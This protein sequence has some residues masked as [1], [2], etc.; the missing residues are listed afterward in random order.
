MN[1]NESPQKLQTLWE[2]QD[3]LKLV[4]TTARD[5]VL[6]VSPYIS[7]NAIRSDNISEVVG[8]AV[9]RGVR[10]QVFIDCQ[11][12][13]YDN[14]KMRSRGLEGIADLVKAGAEVAVVNGID[15]KTLAR[16]NDLI[17]EGS[18]NWLS[19]VRIRSGE[20]QLE[21]GTLMYTGEEAA[22]RISQELARIEE[23]EYEL[24]SSQENSGIE[25]TRAGKV[26]GLCLVLAL[27]FLI[28]KTPGNK[29][30]GIVCMVVVVAVI[31][32]FYWMRS[33]RDDRG[34]PVPQAQ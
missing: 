27:P 10:V 17:T 19:A 26:F 18:F 2:H 8:Q 14:M 3:L 28:G 15:N 33:K 20:C 4:L 13:C 30:A 29:I 24:A 16:D 9:A 22:Q 34:E 7:I 11:R 12:N 25:I 1:E 23:T 6:I 31:A 21:E 32:G 5:R